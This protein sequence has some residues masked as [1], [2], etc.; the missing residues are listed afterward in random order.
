M[1]NSILLDMS[2]EMSHSTKIIDYSLAARV[3]KILSALI[4]AQQ[5]LLSKS[6]NLDH[7]CSNQLKQ[8]TLKSMI[9]SGLIRRKFAFKTEDKKIYQ[10]SIT[11]KGKKYYENHK[12]R[13]CECKAH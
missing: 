7:I 12:S 13:A 6:I 1:A 4:R 11:N 9:H 8:W 3:L 5:P 2:A 10:Y